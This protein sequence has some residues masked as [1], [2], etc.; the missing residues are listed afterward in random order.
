LER[1]LLNRVL[2]KWSNCPCGNFVARIFALF[3][4][5]FGNLLPNGKFVANVQPLG[6]TLR[7]EVMGLSKTSA[8]GIFREDIY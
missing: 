1:I 4:G 2:Q 3:P 7:T 6:T 8:D 5:L